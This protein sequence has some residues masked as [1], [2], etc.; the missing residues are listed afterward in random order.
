MDVGEY[1]KLVV[2]KSPIAQA[3]GY[4]LPCWEKLFI[5]TRDAR[6]NIDNNL[7]ENAIRPLDVGSKNYLFAGSQ[8]AAQRAAIVYSLLPTCKQHN[9]NPYYWLRDV[10]ENMILKFSY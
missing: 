7:V 6:L 8:E 9:I 1:P 2:K 10:L 5:Y 4:F 3:I